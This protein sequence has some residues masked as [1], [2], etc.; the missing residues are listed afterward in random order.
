MATLRTNELR[1]ALDTRTTDL[2]TDTTL[3]AAARWDTGVLNLD[4]PETGSRGVLSAFVLWTFRGNWSTANQM[5][6]IRTGIKLGAAATVDLDR[7]FTQA[8]GN[9]HCG[10]AWLHDVTSYF[11]ANLGAGATQTCIASIAVAT[12]AA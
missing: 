5:I 4:I 11:Q 6:A 10:D 8:G 2:A 7:P 3:S 12:T 1:W 9:V